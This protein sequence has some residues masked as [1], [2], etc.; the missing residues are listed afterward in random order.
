MIMNPQLASPDYWSQFNRQLDNSGVDATSGGV[1]TNNTGVSGAAPGGVPTPTPT[2][3]GAPTAGG[4]QR[5]D[6]AYF[7]STFGSPKTPQELIA[8][9]QQITA[10]GGKVLRNASGVAGKIQTPDGRIIDVINSAGA[11][12][13]GFQWLEGDGGGQNGSNLGSLGYGFGSSMAPFVPPTAEDAINSPGLQ[14]ALGEANRMG[15]NSAAAKGTLLN[16]RF[17]QALNA[18]NIGNALQG[19]QGVFDRAYQTQTRN[20]DAPFDKNYRL[21][22]LGKPS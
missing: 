12:G 20:T 22:T 1:P 13:N 18:S 14:F 19:Y 10:A 7:S 16:G 8:M 2:T 6:Q 11:G 9:E 21:A 4:G 5:W 3:T 17:Q 15:Q